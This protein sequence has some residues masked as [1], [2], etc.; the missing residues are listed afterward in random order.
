MEK[1][2]SRCPTC[3]R[4]FKDRSNR[5]NSY[6]WAVVYQIIADEIGESP[7]AVHKLMKEMHLPRMFVTIGDKERE[8]EKS[9]T[10]LTTS[11]MEDYL[12]RV[13]SWAGTEV[14]CFIPLPNEAPL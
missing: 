8:V 4:S 9:T 13:R 5:Q 10:I 12:T 11:E 2:E 7:E 1:P 14:N 6:L 3:G